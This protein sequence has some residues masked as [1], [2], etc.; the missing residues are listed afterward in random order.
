M[1]L[2]TLL[3]CALLT[4]GAIGLVFS[5]YQQWQ[6]N[7]L[8]RQAEEYELPAVGTEAHTHA[9]H[10]QT[11]AI[12][13]PVTTLLANGLVWSVFALF[14]LTGMTLHTYTGRPPPKPSH[15]I[16]WGLALLAC[17][18][19][20]PWLAGLPPQIPG[21]ER[22]PVAGRQLWWGFCALS[23]AAG[24]ALLYYARRIWRWSGLVLISLPYL[25]PGR[26]PP[27]EFIN[28]DPQAQA[29]L[30]DIAAQFALMSGLGML[31][32]CLAL[33][34]VCAWLT[35]RHLAPLAQP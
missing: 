7:P 10:E 11:Q 2:R 17:I 28:P 21:V 18:S 34:P 9:G 14:L 33:G 5:A 30:A 32:F 8:L 23:T 20:A 12:P 1:L 27:G 29:V 6:L 13:V 26:P 22:S 31:I 4:G 24:I 19:L 16:L 35:R 3:L 15:G 25:L